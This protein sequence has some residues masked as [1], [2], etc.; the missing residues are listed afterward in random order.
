MSILWYLFHFWGT[1]STYISQTWKGQTC[2]EK[3]CCM[4]L[5]KCLPGTHLRTAGSIR[6]QCVK[7]NLWK[8]R[9]LFLDGVDNIIISS[10]LDSTSN[11][12]D[13]VTLRQRLSEH[14]WLLKVLA[15]KWAF[16]WAFV[17]FLLEALFILS[18]VFTALLYFIPFASWKL[19][20]DSIKLSISWLFAN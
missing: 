6:R 15:T 4:C 1:Y 2:L 7:Q 10:I 16:S 17:M 18:S 12:I 11:E 13:D 8:G 20:A 5:N 9:I 14:V 19:P 3:C